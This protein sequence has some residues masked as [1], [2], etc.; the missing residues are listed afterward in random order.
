MHD[1]SEYLPNIL[2][3]KSKNNNF[4]NIL[5]HHVF[6]LWHAMKNL[7]SMIRISFFFNIEKA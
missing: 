6:L 2:L 7:Q 3:K 1:D 5:S 4:I